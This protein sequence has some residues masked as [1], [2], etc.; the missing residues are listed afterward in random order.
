M[1][2]GGRLRLRTNSRAGSLADRAQLG[3]SRLGLVEGFVVSGVS[4]WVILEL[5]SQ[6]QEDEER[7]EDGDEA[8]EGDEEDGD[9]EGE[10]EEEDMSCQL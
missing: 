8:E 1:V 7:G 9:E 3:T 5:G 6:E 4:V 10:E 2:N